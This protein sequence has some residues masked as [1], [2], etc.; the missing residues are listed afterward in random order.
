VLLDEKES[1]ALWRWPIG[2]ARRR[3][4]LVFDDALALI[5]SLRDPAVALRRFRGVGEIIRT[6]NRRGLRLIRLVT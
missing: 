5:A 6:S 4:H 1:L 3:W 2:V